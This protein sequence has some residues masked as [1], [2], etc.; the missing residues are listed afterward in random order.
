MYFHNFEFT[1]CLVVDEKAKILMKS[2][3]YMLGYL[4]SHSSVCVSLNANI[5]SHSPSK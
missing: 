3:N 1:G 5:L 2:F 4:N